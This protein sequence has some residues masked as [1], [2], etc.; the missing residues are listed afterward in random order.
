[1]SKG[2]AVFSLD[3]RF[4]VKAANGNNAH[5]H[6]RRRRRVIG[7]VICEQIAQRVPH[8]LEDERRR[9]VLGPIEVL[10]CELTNPGRDAFVQPSFL[11]PP[12][13]QPARVLTGHAARTGQQPQVSSEVASALPQCCRMKV[14]LGRFHQRT[15]ID[16]HRATKTVPT[17][18]TLFFVAFDIGERIADVLKI[19]MDAALFQ[20]R[21]YT[22]PLAEK[23][24]VRALSRL[25]AV[26][27]TECLLWPLAP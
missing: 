21:S 18:N 16:V 9:F 24:A 3:H 22:T 13:I 10:P 17:R 26:W 19:E 23:V 15:E 27:A 6:C 8:R 4:H 2:I 12:G 11:K 1:M 5:L 25:K 20:P 14:Q 7:L